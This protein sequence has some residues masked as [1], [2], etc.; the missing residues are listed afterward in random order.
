MFS[1]IYCL[2]LLFKLI[3]LGK[4]YFYDYWNLFD[5]VTT[6][7]TIVGFFLGWFIP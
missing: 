5:F 3:G 6:F 2:E 1:I 7:G 4:V